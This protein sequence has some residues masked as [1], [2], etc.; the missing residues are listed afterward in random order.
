[1]KTLDLINLSL[2]VI[3]NGHLCSETPCRGGALPSRVVTQADQSE[4]V[5]RSLPQ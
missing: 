1:M 4:L 3:L 2:Q 5:Y